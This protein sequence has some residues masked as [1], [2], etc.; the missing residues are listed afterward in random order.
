[1]KTTHTHKDLIETLT[2]ALATCMVHGEVD[3][4]KFLDKY[5]KA[6][7]FQQHIRWN[8]LIMGCISQYNGYLSGAPKTHIIMMDMFGAHQW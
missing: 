4:D 1:M 7:N 8:Q 3:V 2:T 6:L 5:H